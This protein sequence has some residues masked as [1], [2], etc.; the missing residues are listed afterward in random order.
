MTG[1]VQDVVVAGSQHIEEFRPVAFSREC[2]STS[3]PLLVH[4]PN[5]RC[6]VAI[7]RSLAARSSIAASIASTMASTLIT[8]GLQELEQYEQRDGPGPDIS[9]AI[10]VLI[11]YIMIN[12]E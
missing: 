3:I 8:N 4:F 9:I 6:K 10:S 7:S 2:L 12:I 11:K 1:E 5:N